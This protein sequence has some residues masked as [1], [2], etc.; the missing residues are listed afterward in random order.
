M[1]QK[2][3]F[4]VVAIALFFWGLYIFLFSWIVPKMAYAAIPQKWMHLPMMQ[5]RT[6]L[7]SYLGNPVEQTGVHNPET[8]VT[9]N[10]GKQYR[11]R[12]YYIGDS[13]VAH[14]AVYY[15]L[16]KTWI[17]KSFLIDTASVR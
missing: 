6:I 9:G 16:H 14:Y 1:K 17:H 2:I 13:L 4:W 7:H 3:G 8:W 15:Q 12:V 11:L 5:S 10:A